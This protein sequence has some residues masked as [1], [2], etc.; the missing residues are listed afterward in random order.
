MAEADDGAD[1]LTADRARIARAVDRA[2][3]WLAA[4]RRLSSVD[5]NAVDRL[6]ADLL[7]RTRHLVAGG[8]A[9]GPFAPPLLAS[10][11]TGFHDA[12]LTAL[13]D[14]WA[15]TAPASLIA[16]GRLLTRWCRRWRRCP[17]RCC[18]MVACMMPPRWNAI[19]ACW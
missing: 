17:A 12:V 14:G 18:R 1:S 8:V 16:A 6:G 5:D 13:V 3:G 10:G 15:V 19:W 11:R 2:A 4:A 7:E 9:T